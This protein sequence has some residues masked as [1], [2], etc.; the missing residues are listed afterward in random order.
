M[1]RAGPTDERDE[2][3][4]ARRRGDRPVEL[5]AYLVD[6]AHV[7]AAKRVHV[8]ELLFESD[9]VVH[10]HLDRDDD[11]LLL[12]VPLAEEDHVGH[13]RG[14]ADDPQELVLAEASVV[15]VADA[16]HV[17]LAVRF[18]E[19]RE[20]IIL[21]DAVDFDVVPTAARTGEGVAGVEDVFEI[22]LGISVAVV[23]LAVENQVPIPSDGSFLVDLHPEIE[24]RLGGSRLGEDGDID[25]NGPD[26]DV[27]HVEV[28]VIENFVSVVV[29]PCATGN[30]AAAGEVAVC[31]FQNR[32]FA[33]AV[34][35]VV[36]AEAEARILHSVLLRAVCKD[37]DVVL[38]VGTS[39]VVRCAEV[40]ALGPLGEVTQ[41]GAPFDGAPTGGGVS[42]LACLYMAAV[43]IS[44]V[45][46]V[47]QVDESTIAGE[48]VVANF[49][50]LPW[51]VWVFH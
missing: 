46:V 30:D 14:G 10:A 35:V 6:C 22:R 49:D 27:E 18:D 3:Q 33:L 38:I 40:F 8:A 19:V 2:F 32:G 43:I 20:G 39:P 34:T 26:I 7:R 44:L 47:G 42:R 24:V 37:I 4:V 15:A 21:A 50:S 9:H 31:D 41:H 5:D 48:V 16:D 17:A 36:G 45:V 28:V 11:S 29:R 12:V 25:W 23:S 13:A 51:I 1:G